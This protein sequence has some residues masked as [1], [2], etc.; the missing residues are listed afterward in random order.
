MCEKFT[1]TPPPAGGDLPVTSHTLGAGGPIPAAAKFQALH[2]PVLS[3]EIG[4]HPNAS[5]I[6]TSTAMVNCLLKLGGNLI[7]KVKFATLVL[8]LAVAVSSTSAFAHSS[9]RTHHRSYNSMNM[10]N[11]HSNAAGASKDVSGTTGSASGGGASGAGG[12]AGG[13]AGGGSAGGSGK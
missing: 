8:A 9:K 1:G 3:V 12:A 5:P 11:G 2:K 6:G 13:G 7:M 4:R 10:M